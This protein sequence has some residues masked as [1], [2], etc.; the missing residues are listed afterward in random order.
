MRP[1]SES[2]PLE[3]AGLSASPMPFTVAREVTPAEHREIRRFE[4]ENKGFAERLAAA[5]N[6]AVMTEAAR[7]ADVR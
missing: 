1:L 5:L 3:S 4:G 2:V 6:S 7:D